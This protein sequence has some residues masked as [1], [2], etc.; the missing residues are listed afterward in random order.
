LLVFAPVAQ[1][2]PKVATYTGF[3]EL[4]WAGRGGF[5]DCPQGIEVTWDQSLATSGAANGYNGLGGCH[6]WLNP[7]R[8]RHLIR[9][10][11]CTL[12]LHEYGHLVG[13]S[14]ESDPRHIMYPDA[15]IHP[16][17]RRFD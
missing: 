3:A 6:I 2:A 4:F 8:W 1:A 17:C 11:R 9:A 12:I 13:L 15:R 16:S 5:T 7:D 14:H 10:V